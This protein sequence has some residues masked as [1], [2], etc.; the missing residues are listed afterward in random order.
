MRVYDI[1]YK[2]RNGDQLS[3]QEIDFIVYNYNNGEI[4]DYQMSAFLMAVFFTGMTD[5][6]I[7][8]LTYAMASSG[9]IMDL[10]SFDMPTADKHS[11]GGVGDGTSLILAPIAASAG[12]CV[13]M[14]SGRGLGHTGGT[15]DKLESIP[16][17]RTD[18]G[19][20]ELLD[21][22]EYA[23]IAL[24]GQTVEIAPVDK[25][26]YA[27]RD[28]TATV[29]S[30]PLICA[31]IMSKKIAEGVDTLIL[32]VKTGNGAFMKNM[33]DSKELA[34]KMIMIGRK[35]NKNISAY[36]TDMNTPLGNCAGNSIE[37][38]QSIDILKGDLK[39]D[40]SY[41]S[42]E[43]AA[44]MVYNSKKAG[45]MEEGR[46]IAQK[47][48]DSGKAIEK[49]RQIIKMQGGNP[50]VIDSPDTVLPQAKNSLYIKAAKSG[51]ISF[52]DTRSIG[53][54]SMMTGAGRE[55]KEDN[56]DLSAGIRFYKKTGDQVKEGEIIA[57]LLYNSS[58]RI[59][60][61][62]IIMNN[63]Y[64]ISSDTETIKEPLIKEIIN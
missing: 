3:K 11:T 44:A 58:G 52:M 62:E 61:A 42:I 33:K 35:F 30:I 60:E 4:A 14:M 24:I 31:S 46:L 26:M 6:E 5:E 12:L 64:V 17:F 28:A 13:P 19:K 43:L 40:L 37:I 53:I 8:N 23:G 32:D 20:K 29:E 41:L 45:S 2:K 47:M 15:L 36:I 50:D 56:I 21:F 48:I 49:F 9:D 39:N 22:L 51:Y 16:G 7:Y 54:A 55:K 27:L 57:E 63:S 59:S 10:S 1:I 34:L 25:K 18:I 38:K